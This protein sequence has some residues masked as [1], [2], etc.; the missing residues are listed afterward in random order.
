MKVTSFFKSSNHYFPLIF[1]VWI[2]CRLIFCP[3]PSITSLSLIHH[4]HSL[5]IC[6]LILNSYLLYFQLSFQHLTAT[7]T[8]CLPPKLQHSGCSWRHWLYSDLLPPLHG[9]VVLAK[10][11]AGVTSHWFWYVLPH[12]VTQKTKRNFTQAMWRWQ[13]I[14]EPGY[15]FFRVNVWTILAQL[16]AESIGPSHYT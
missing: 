2:Y 15:H 1:L 6:D 5:C 12:A 13:G 14:G 9:V 3:Y 10:S 11:L 8:L 7:I 16:A 4:L